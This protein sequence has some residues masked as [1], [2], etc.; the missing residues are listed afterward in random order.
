M[1]SFFFIVCLGCSLDDAS[2]F[3]APNATTIRFYRPH[4]DCISWGDTL[5][6]PRDGKGAI[7]RF[8]DTGHFEMQPV[9]LLRT[10]TGV[11][12]HHDG[13]DSGVFTSTYGFFYFVHHENAVYLVP[14]EFL[15]LFFNITQIGFDPGSNRI[16]TFY[17]AKADAQVSLFLHSQYQVRWRSWLVTRNYKGVIDRVTDDLAYLTVPSSVAIPV[18][19]ILV[20][21]ENISKDIE[22]AKGQEFHPIGLAKVV[23]NRFDGIV[24]KAYRTPGVQLKPG[25]PIRGSLLDKP[26]ADGVYADY[27]RLP[28]RLPTEND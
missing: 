14:E 25:M 1:L 21:G 20:V 10:Q 24:I 13:I 28:I 27:L 11:Y 17:K 26:T 8:V 3:F 23:S 12:V 6:F 16:M 5:L 4:E 9:L 7:V 18:G 15:P 19:T 22:Y 2:S